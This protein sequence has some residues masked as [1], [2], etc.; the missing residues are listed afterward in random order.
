[1]RLLNLGCGP[2][3]HND[4]VNVDFYQTG[5]NVIA[6]NLLKGIPFESNSFDAIYHSH[7]LEHFSK[8][9]ACSFIK[10]CY[11]V[12][13]PNGTIRIV[14]PDLEKIAI[15]YLNELNNSLNGIPG[16]ADNY[17]WMMIEL[18][19]QVVR[20][21]GGGELIPYIRNKA[22]KNKDF[23]YKR[24][25]IQMTE[26][27]ILP[28]S[29]SSIQKSGISLYDK[30]MSVFSGSQWKNRFLRYLIGEEGVKQWYIGQYRSNGE[31]HQWMYDRYS[32]NQLL[33]EQGFKQ[34]MVKS[35]TD[36]QINNW[37]NYQLDVVNGE[38]RKPDSLFMEA[39]K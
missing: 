13:K 27:E 3:F 36:S 32:L 28:I 39:S 17:N 15:N 31:I 24:I 2:H 14:I 29:E 12:L 20:N 5:P 9:D 23:V 7:V 8:K 38:I 21:T 37:A 22:I 18:Y 16:A 11:R 6:H 34:V 26:I 30:L 1:M 25:G 19:D 10:E 33:Q 35:A 4:W